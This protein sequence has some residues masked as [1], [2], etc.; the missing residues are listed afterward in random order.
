MELEV[1][2]I[3]RPVKACYRH[4]IV[5]LLLSVAPKTAAS[6]HPIDLDQKVISNVRQKLNK[7][8]KTM[9]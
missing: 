5:Q 2:I 4:Y 9:E 7:Q 3:L 8:I 1:S 6:S